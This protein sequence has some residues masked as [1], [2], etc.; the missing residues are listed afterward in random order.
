[1][2]GRQNPKSSSPD[3]KSSSGRRERNGGDRWRQFRTA[4]RVPSLKRAGPEVVIGRPEFV[5]WEAGVLDGGAH[6]P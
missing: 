3:R 4:V 2:H 1:M 6:A 5:I